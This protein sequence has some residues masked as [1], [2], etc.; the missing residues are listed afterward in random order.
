MNADI[1]AGEPLENLIL[2]LA[3]GDKERREKAGV[4]LFLFIHGL[5]D[6]AEYKR[7]EKSEDTHLLPRFK[8][9]N[10][11][12]LRLA[13]ATV[14]SKEG[15]L[16]VETVKALANDTLE[17][18][19]FRYEALRAENQEKYK[20]YFQDNRRI[21]LDFAIN[22]VLTALGPGAKDALP[23]LI[24]LLDRD[25]ETSW[26]PL[27]LAASATASMGAHAAPAFD[28]LFSRFCKVNQDTL[29]EALVRIA[30]ESPEALA[31]TIA[32]TKA[33]NAEHPRNAFIILDKLG[34]QVPDLC[35][36][37]IRGLADGDESVQREAAILLRRHFPNDMDA[38]AAL[39]QAQR[40]QSQKPAQNRIKPDSPWMREDKSIFEWILILANADEA[41]KEKA[42]SCL[43]SMHFEFNDVRVSLEEFG[44]AVMRA[45]ALPGFPATKV[46]KKLIYDLREMVE[47]N[48]GVTGKQ[49]SDTHVR[50]QFA[51]RSGRQ[52]VLT[53]IIENAGPAGAGALDDLVAL[54]NT[55]KDNERH[56]YILGKTGGNALCKLGA[57]ALPA[58]WA[59]LN[60][61]AVVDG[62]RWPNP[63]ENALVKLTDY[64]PGLIAQLAELLEHG[65][66][67]QRRVAA[68]VLSRIGARALPALNAAIRFADA[69]GADAEKVVVRVFAAIS[70]VS[71]TARARLIR[72]AEHSDVDTRACA[73]AGTRDFPE[74]T[75]AVRLL[76]RGLKD[77]EVYVRWKALCTLCDLPIP[78][79][80]KIGYCLKMLGDKDGCDNWIPS[81]EAVRRLKDLG[82]AAAPA[83]PALLE[84]SDADIPLRIAI[85]ENVA[86]AAA[87]PALPW[88]K[89]HLTELLLSDPLLSF[90]GTRRVQT[91]IE[92]LE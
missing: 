27:C 83:V 12:A 23:F 35:G 4:G 7:L 31:K 20:E 52:L 41:G 32:L 49:L 66:P 47:C 59:L 22:C 92:R 87:K 11:N 58:F 54:L 89:E 24:E 68:R 19:R 3:S 50:S 74:T 51:I 17:L 71:D 44:N 61:A 86:P 40:Q 37:A 55:S 82:A 80:A 18:D 6:L 45:F 78:E 26:T 43:R 84:Q 79:P 81:E 77:A 13:V 64:D 5:S 28:A 57:A 39:E 85:L 72:L 88:L 63:S 16:V 76:E 69:G 65:E 25:I 70:G 91:L 10:Q 34:P 8:P 21:Y 46:L 15:F 30:S 62:R 33:E 48:R 75:E 60:N 29:L 73:L 90:E 2:D 67:Q 36:I 1:I 38:L 56:T 42:H 9:E 53:L 14:F